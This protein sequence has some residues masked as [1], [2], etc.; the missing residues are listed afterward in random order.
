MKIRPIA[1]GF[2]EH[3]GRILLQQYWH[4]PEQYH[5]F[6]LAGGGIEFGESA[7]EAMRR[8]A[9]EELSAEI[10]DPELV[11][12]FENLF[13]YGGD[14][15]HEIVFIFRAQLLN[16]ELLAADEFT[17]ADDGLPFRA[18]WVPREEILAGQHVVYPVRFREM[19]L[20]GEL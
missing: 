2:F 5:F 19:L 13:E 11:A 17:M 16:D 18:V 12:V 3:R 14:P 9:R 6:R 4:E 8:E 20:R 7:A 15:K 10:S 1:L